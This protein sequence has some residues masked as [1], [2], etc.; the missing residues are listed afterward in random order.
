MAEL[1]TLSVTCSFNVGFT[2]NITTP[3]YIWYNCSTN[4]LQYSFC[5]S[6]WSAGGALS[7]ARNGLAGAGTQNAA[8]AF[9]GRLGGPS[10]TTSSCTEEYDGSTWSSGGALII[11]RRVLAGTGTQNEALA[12]GGYTP[13][14]SCT[15]EYNGSTWS[16]GGA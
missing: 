7:T 6:S 1:A 12:F 13:G 2:C 3:G 15:E 11:A 16:A 14:G 8:L 9:G 10:Y 5:G 4:R